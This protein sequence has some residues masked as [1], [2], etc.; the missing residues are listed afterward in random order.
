[1]ADQ[2]REQ[3]RAIIAFRF[4]FASAPKYNHRARPS[5]LQDG[6][7]QARAADADKPERLFRAAA[8]RNL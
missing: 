7:W 6:V 2:D 5:F 3:W 1:M 4:A 8:R